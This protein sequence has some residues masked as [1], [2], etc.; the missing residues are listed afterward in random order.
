MY[1]VNRFGRY[2]FF[3]S[4]IDH[5]KDYGYLLRKIDIKGDTLPLRVIYF[6]DASWEVGIIKATA[7]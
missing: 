2:T 6:Q 1:Q 3:D 7:P 4:D 5:R